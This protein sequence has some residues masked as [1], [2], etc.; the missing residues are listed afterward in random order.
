MNKK[1]LK[2]IK[3]KISV[4]KITADEG[5]TEKGFSQIERIRFKNISW[6]KL[7]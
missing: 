1:K 6:R 4:L 2:K 3:K 5:N 7:C